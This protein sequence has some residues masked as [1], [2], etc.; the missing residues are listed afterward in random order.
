ML[1]VACLAAQQKSF[2]NSLDH[3]VSIDGHRHRNTQR[4][5]DCTML[6]DEHIEHNTVNRV[7]KPV[8]GDD[9]YLFARLP[10]AV[11]PSLTLF[12]ARRV[13]REIIVDNPVEMLLQVD[14]F[15]HA[16]ST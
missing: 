15:A 3:L 1:C 14:A 12:M 2:E 13:P 10:I 4:A 7:V 9:S 11:H 16:V 6:A 8:V 5:A